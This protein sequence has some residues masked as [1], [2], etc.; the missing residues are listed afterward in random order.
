MPGTGTVANRQMFIEATL[1][2][3]SILFSKGDTNKSLWEKAYVY[4][5][6][7]SLHFTIQRSFSLQD[8]SEI[9]NTTCNDR[10]YEKDIML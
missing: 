3:F 9:H 6:S 10:L 8:D 5:K 4:P 1:H 2:G 7:L